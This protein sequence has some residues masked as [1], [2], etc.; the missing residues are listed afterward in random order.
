MGSNLSE[1]HAW[2]HAGSRLPT[3]PID[4]TA[5]VRR[6]RFADGGRFIDEITKLTRARTRP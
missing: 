1:D 6:T 5:Q 3:V 2:A 4:G